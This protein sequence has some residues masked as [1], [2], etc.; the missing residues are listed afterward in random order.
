M[1]VKRTD[2]R[3]RGGK[4][5]IK[6]DGAMCSRIK[7]LLMDYLSPEQISGR[8]KLELGVEISHETIYRHIWADKRKGGVLYKQLRSQGKRYRKR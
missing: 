5:K 1:A 3:R 2:R 8:L 4:K 7:T 6:L